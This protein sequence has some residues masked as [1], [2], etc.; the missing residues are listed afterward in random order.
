MTNIVS[1]F[2][3]T[4]RMLKMFKQREPQQAMRLFVIQLDLPGGDGAVHLFAALDERSQDGAPRRFRRRGGDGRRRARHAG[5]MP[6]IVNWGWIIGAIGAGRGRRRSAFAGAADRRAAADRAL[7]RL[8]RLGR[9][10][11]RS[12]RSITSGCGEGRGAS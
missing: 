6:G 3:I 8:R 11:G 2:L 9:G 5:S 7:A 4:D 12:R 1:G 10:A